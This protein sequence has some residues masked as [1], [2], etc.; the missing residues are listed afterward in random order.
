M[1]PRLNIDKLLAGISAA[2]PEDRRRMRANAE[3]WLATGSDA[4]REAA[5]RL[6]D[7]MDDRERNEHDA[8]V[9]ELRGLDT[10]ERV[11]RAFTVQPMSETEAKLIQVLLD[12]PGSTSRK[13]T[14]ALGWKAQSWHMHFGTMCAKRALY[15]WPAPEADG[16]D[17]KFFCGILA[18][19]K[20]PE[21]LFTMK[22]DAA[23]AFAK[24][25]LAPRA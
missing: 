19:L 16:R 4:Q 12:H 14:Q 17:G 9:G 3:G 18:D 13:L 21:N 20:E 22:P 7:A 2:S 24:L 6:V 23:A 15:L 1:R 11:I 25:G 5:R 10:A 8:L